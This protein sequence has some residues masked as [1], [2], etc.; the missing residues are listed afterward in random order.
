MENIDVIKTVS[1]NIKCPVC[2][3]NELNLL[4]TT[5][6]IPYFGDILIMS[7]RCKNC[8]FKISDIMA[9]T[10]E[11]KRTLEEKITAKTLSDLLVL[12]ANSTVEIPELGIELDIRTEMGGQITTIEG[13]LLELL[14][15]S[16]Q[17]LNTQIGEKDREHIE[18]VIKKLTG[19]KVSPSG[20]LTIKILDETGKSA[21]I[22]YELWSKRAEDE[23]EKA[24]KIDKKLVE[25]L[26]GEVIKKY[27]KGDQ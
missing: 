17:M 1:L 12:S 9:I 24:K 10:Y 8:G 4:Y 25:D 6:H 18:N 3:K 16:K 5:S 22:P 21:I 19:E 7:I 13:L 15:Y 26:A 20:S 11:K 23:R 14:Q 27:S 2:Y